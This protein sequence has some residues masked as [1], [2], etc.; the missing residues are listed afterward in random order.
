MLPSNPILLQNEAILKQG[1]AMRYGYTKGMAVTLTDRRLIFK[2]LFIEEWFPL[3]HI[4]SI[5]KS[6]NFI[7]TK[8]DNGY[9][10]EFSIPAADELLGEIEKARVNAPEMD[11]ATKAPSS[12][13]V[14]LSKTTIIVLAAGSVAVFS[15]GC[16]LLVAA[17][18]YRF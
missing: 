14:G 2:N 17:L 13:G 6:G 11:Y 15:I 18:I 10:E 16:C 7:I 5:S 9:T 4:K 12:S 8:F 1:I 3:S